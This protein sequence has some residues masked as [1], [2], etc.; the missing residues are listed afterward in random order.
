MRRFR[1][2]R[3]AIV[4]NDTTIGIPKLTPPYRRIPLHRRRPRSAIVRNKPR[5][6]SKSHLVPLKR[7]Y[8]LKNHLNI[9]KDHKIP[10]SI[11]IKIRNAPIGC[12]IRNPTK[13]G[14]RKIKVTK[15]LKRRAIATLNLRGR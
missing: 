5:S 1:E 8:P 11:L 13:V 4:R 12:I 9:P 7:K 2:S 6:Y 3:Q 15:L 14:K 10:T